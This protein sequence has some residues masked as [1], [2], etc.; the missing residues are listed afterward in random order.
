MRG[1]REERRKQNI[2]TYVPGD[3]VVNDLETTF[4][5][6]E[7]INDIENFE[8]LPRQTLLTIITAPKNE[9]YVKVLIGTQTG[10]IDVED[11]GNPK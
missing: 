6:T 2:A 8:R 7:D 3:I 4:W 10:W 9:R 11:I 5:L 1:R